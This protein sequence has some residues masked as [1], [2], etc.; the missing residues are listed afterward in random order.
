MSPE[1]LLLIDTTSASETA[2]NS[3]I[4]GNFVNNLPEMT[5]IIISQRISSIRD[6]D[7][8]IVMDDGK[9]SGI[10]AHEDLLNTNEIYKDIFELQ[11]SDGEGDFDKKEAKR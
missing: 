1:I 10:G 3:K 9:I 8:I 4:R 6:A 2:T 11:N 5:K 7:R